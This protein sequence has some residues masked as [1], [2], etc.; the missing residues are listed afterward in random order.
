[1]HN[2]DVMHQESN[3]CQALINTCMDFL[4]KTKDNDKARMD[5]AVICDCPTQVL[6]ENG[7]KPKADYCLKPKQRKEVMKWMEGIKFPDGYAAGFRRSVNLN[8]MKMN[9]LKNHDFHIIMERLMPV[10]FRGYISEAVWK[11]LAEVSYFYIQLCANEII[12]D[13]M[14]QLEKEAP[15]LLCKLEKIFPPGFFNP[16]QHLFIHL[17]Y[18]AKVG[19]PV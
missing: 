18:E 6:R 13:V 15:V 9:G 16:M 11:T 8:T 4:D 17:P 10:M 1:M 12:R 2:I 14:E 7:G 5:L 19:G 3:F